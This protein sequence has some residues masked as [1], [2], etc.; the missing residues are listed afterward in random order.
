MRISK[1]IKIVNKLKETEV[2]RFSFKKIP[3][4]GNILITGRRASGKTVCAL[5]LVR[6]LTTGRDGFGSVVVFTNAPDPYVDAGM[7]DVHAEFDLDVFGHYIDKQVGKRNAGADTENMEN[8]LLVV[9]DDN[10]PS[11]ALTEINQLLRISKHLMMGVI[12]V[13]TQ[14]SLANVNTKRVQCC[15]TTWE[16]H[17]LSQINVNRKFFPDLDFPLFK[18]M[19]SKHTTDYGVLINHFGAKKGKHHYFKMK[20]QKAN[21]FQ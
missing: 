10:I 4:R 18:K 17:R 5:D 3:K 15:F 20:A 7:A 16:P 19:L 6:Q 11:D 2:S 12:L 13:S 21:I 1:L 9:I 8:W 14:H